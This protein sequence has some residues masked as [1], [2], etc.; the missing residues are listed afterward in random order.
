MTGSNGSYS[1]TSAKGSATKYKTDNKGQLTLIG[2]PNGTY[3]IYEVTAPTG[4]TLSQQSASNGI[5]VTISNGKNKTQTIK[6]KLRR[7]N[8]S[9]GWCR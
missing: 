7:F 4:Y 6:N 9:K 2:I 8:N 1:E 5:N 3:T